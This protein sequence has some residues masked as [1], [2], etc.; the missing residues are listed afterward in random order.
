MAGQ[1]T[2][3]YLNQ[4]WIIVDWAIGNI[5]QWKLNQNTT[6]FIEE[7]QFENVAWKMSAILSQAQCCSRYLDNCRSFCL[8]LQ[9]AKS[10]FNVLFRN[11]WIWSQGSRDHSV[12]VLSQWEMALHCNTIS[13]WLGAYTE[14]AVGLCHS[15]MS[16]STWLPH[17]APSLP[18]ICYHYSSN[19]Y[20]IHFHFPW[21]IFSWS[22]WA[23]EICLVKPRTPEPIFACV[24][25]HP[26]CC[27]PFDRE[28]IIQL[29]W[30]K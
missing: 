1:V 12:Y 4:C 7:N 26:F 8:Q 13:H 28:A 14:L 18:S 29:D 3:H 2:S 11:F 6:I 19:E 21:Q 15:I 10:G 16:M 24:S 20:L 22:Q 23:I 5:F 27:V 17:Q 25:S 9:C 30:R